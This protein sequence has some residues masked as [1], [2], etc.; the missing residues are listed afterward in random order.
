MDWFQYKNP[1]RKKYL[2]TFFVCSDYKCLIKLKQKKIFFRSNW[3]RRSWQ[4][5]VI[6]WS[7]WRSSATSYSLIPT[8]PPTVEWLK[9]CLIGLRC[10]PNSHDDN[11]RYQINTSSSQTN[12][13]GEPKIRFNC[14]HSLRKTFFFLISTI[15]QSN[16]YSHVM[17]GLLFFRRRNFNP[18]FHII[19]ITKIKW[20]QFKYGRFFYFLCTCVTTGISRIFFCLE[21]FDL[22]Q[23]L[24]LFLFHIKIRQRHCFGITQ[25]CYCGIITNTSVYYNIIQFY[26]PFALNWFLI[27]SSI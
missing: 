9:R 8:K 17:Y 10:R 26:L 1:F 15:C 18:F 24:L 22:F 12:L 11:N 13:V 4:F 21:K 16:E 7:T 2:A 19:R 3:A 27:T 14:L 6:L 20:K 23:I 5:A 25:S